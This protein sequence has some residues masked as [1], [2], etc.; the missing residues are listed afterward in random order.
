ML[1]QD[2]PIE[3][4][5]LEELFGSNKVATSLKRLNEIH[6]FAEAKWGEYVSRIPNGVIR[7]LLI[8][9][10][11]PWKATGAPWFVL[12]PDTPSR[13]LMAALRSTFLNDGQVT[14]LATPE[15]LTELARRGFLL[16]D[17]IPFSMRYSSTQ[18]T[19]PHYWKL[20]ARTAQTYLRRK[21]MWPGLSWS[22]S[23][24]VAFA[25]KLNAKAIIEALEGQLQLG[26]AIRPLGPDLI[27]ASS[28]GFPNAGR[29]K[30]IYALP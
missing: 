22:P 10:A 25:F 8:A 12:D 3:L 20:I 4:A 1:Q 13:T 29:L 9:E 5:I 7:Y 18:R 19:S 2:F 26:D 27:A 15:A 16:I 24:R 30:S 28:S 11:P 6:T 23:V 14:R 17:S 21:I